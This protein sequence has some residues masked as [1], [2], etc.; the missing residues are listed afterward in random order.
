MTLPHNTV[1]DDAKEGP[2]A[3]EYYTYQSTEPSSR[4]RAFEEST[5]AA[6]R[7]ARQARRERTHARI[8]R[9]PRNTLPVT[10]LLVLLAATVIT[11]I[12]VGAP[13]AIAIQLGSVMAAAYGLLNDVRVSIAEENPDWRARH[14]VAAFFFRRH[15]LDRD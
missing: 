12:T 9:I 6:C 2:V 7:E 14:R 4:R 3:T 15:P 1:T 8:T 5:M 11:G 10:G 13:S